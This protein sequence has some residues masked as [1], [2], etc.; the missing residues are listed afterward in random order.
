MGYKTN[1]ENRGAGYRRLASH[2]KIV[3]NRAKE[4]LEKEDYN[5]I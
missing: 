5:F 1:E 4:I 3:H 2:R